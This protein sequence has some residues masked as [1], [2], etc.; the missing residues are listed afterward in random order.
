[1]IRYDAM[2]CDAMRYVFIVCAC[3]RLSVRAA[4]VKQMLT[5]N[6]RS[7]EVICIIANWW[8]RV[9]RLNVE[10]GE[11]TSTLLVV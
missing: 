6:Q 5:S 3:V 10:R 2:R 11:W 1:M 4:K 8:M 7:N 9:K